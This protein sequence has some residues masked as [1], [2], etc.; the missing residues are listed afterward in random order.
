GA[1]DLLLLGL[2]PEGAVL[3][4]ARVALA[5][6]SPTAKRMCRPAAGGVAVDRDVA[7][8]VGALHALVAVRDRT[9]ATERI[10]RRRNRSRGDERQRPDGRCPSGPRGVE[11]RRRDLAEHNILD[12]L[13][14]A[15]TVRRAACN[16][17]D[18]S[19]G[20]ERE[21]SPCE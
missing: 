10:L 1:V 16:E 20:R 21:H 13:A 5:R 3:I 17:Q 14:L 12:Q 15:L 9:L 7:G 18:H 2:A 8:A 6:A 11:L 4:D 19:E